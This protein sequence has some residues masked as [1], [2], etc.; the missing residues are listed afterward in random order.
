MSRLLVALFATVALVGL[1]AE[2]PP[3]PPPAPPQQK[4]ACLKA[5]A[6]DPRGADGKALLACLTRCDA[7]VDAGVR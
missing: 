7:T 1:A 4:A 2:A 5:C 6:G 3:A